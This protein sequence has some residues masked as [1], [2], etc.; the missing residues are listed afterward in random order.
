MHEG[1][2]GQAGAGARSIFMSNRNKGLIR[3][4]N[5][6]KEIKGSA[7]YSLKRKHKCSLPISRGGRISSYGVFECGLSVERWMREIKLFKLKDFVCFFISK[8]LLK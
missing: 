2:E 8:C 4:Y 6:R 7:C 5:V 3:N 1:S